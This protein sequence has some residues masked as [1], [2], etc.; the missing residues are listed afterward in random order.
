MARPAR[1]LVHQR[2]GEA[3]TA[4][5][6]RHGGLPSADQTADIWSEIWHHETHHSTAVEG[7]TLALADVQLL[8]VDGQ[9][10]GHRPLADYLEVRA[11]ATAAKWVYEQTRHPD[12]GRS[13]ELLALHEVRFL[14][15]QALNLPWAVAAP[16]HATPQEAPGNFRRHEIASF[17]RGMKPP[18]WVEVDA[19]MHDWV[20]EANRVTQDSEIPVVEQLAKLHGEFER[21]HPFLDGNGRVGRL[22]LNL[23][24]ARLGYPPA[25][26]YKR[27][28]DRYLRALHRS[29]Q[30]DSGLLGELIAR[31]VTDNLYR[32]LLPVVVDHDELLPLIA[33]ASYGSEGALRAAAVRGRLRAVKGD[34]GA[35][36]ST[37][38]WVS[39]Y[40]ES[41]YRRG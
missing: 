2:L 20:Q 10:G 26:I 5:Y 11:Y 25:I 15:H 7:N 41:R 6:E 24:L 35:W 18:S 19:L 28:R 8:L 4:L 40:R 29:D 22:V 38:A 1:M 37:K 32:F 9:T 16:A 14:H 36:R 17:G 31:S 23:L 39:E 12:V 30:G 27:D 3:V 34:D 21:I 33:F 13:E